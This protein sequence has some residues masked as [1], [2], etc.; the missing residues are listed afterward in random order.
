MKKLRLSANSIEN[1]FFIHKYLRLQAYP[2]T[3]IKANVLAIPNQQPAQQYEKEVKC[4]CVCI[5]RNAFL[6]AVAVLSAF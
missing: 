4:L 6:S 2:V 5:L 1:V 3:T